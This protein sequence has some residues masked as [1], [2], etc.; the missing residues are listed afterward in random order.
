MGAHERTKINGNG[1]ISTSIVINQPLA[2]A[3]DSDIQT[4]STPL[5]LTSGSA[6]QLPVVPLGIPSL[7]W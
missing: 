2:G 1:C 6:H 4:R 7:V 5:A 3:G